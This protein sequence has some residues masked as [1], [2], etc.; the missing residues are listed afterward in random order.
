MNM[1]SFVVF[2]GN[3]GKEYER[4]RHNAGWMAASLIGDAGD[5]ISWPKKFHGRWTTLRIGNH[6]V[7]LL[8]PLT[9]MNE[10]GRSV[11][12]ALTF[13]SLSPQD[14][15]VVHDDIEL[16]FGMVVLQQG[17]GL[18]GHN[19]LKSIAQ[20]L[21]SPEFGRLRLGIGRPAHGSVSSFVTSRFSREE[22]IILPLILSRSCECIMK[23]CTTGMPPEPLR[24]SLP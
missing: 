17:G 7:R 14:I 12:E 2:L 19:G 21:S 16:P 13:F 6:P 11:A 1:I 22:E 18:Q 20:A 8:Q 24:I 9:Y 5:P 3:P 10:S 4:T 23:A 15:L